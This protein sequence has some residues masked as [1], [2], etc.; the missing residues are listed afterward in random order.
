MCLLNSFV[1]NITE[2]ILLVNST[3]LYHGI[4]IDKK[5]KEFYFRTMAFDINCRSSI[6]RGATILK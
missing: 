2:G 1:V 6:I 5:G 3:V 4:K